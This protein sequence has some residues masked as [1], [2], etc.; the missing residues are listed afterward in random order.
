NNRRY[1]K[2]ATGGITCHDRS[3]SFTVMEQ[4]LVGAHGII[5]RRRKQVLGCKAI[6][7]NEDTCFRREREMTRR[8]TSGGGRTEHES[9]AKE[10]KNA[11]PWRNDG[12]FRPEPINFGGRRKM[13]TLRFAREILRVKIGLARLG[14]PHRGLR[15]LSEIG[16]TLSRQASASQ[17]R[18]RK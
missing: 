12:R 8:F 15:I 3:G 17:R 10:I 7:W 4:E 16:S 11:S 18:F 13:D 9:A 6:V 14:K 1:G 5:E 2:P